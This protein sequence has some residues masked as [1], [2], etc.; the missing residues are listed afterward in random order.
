MKQ[1]IRTIKPEF[2]LHENL[3][4]AEQ[5]TGLP[6][7]MAFVGLWTCADREG[8]FEW[9]PRP[10]KACIMPYD[11]VDFSA[12]LDALSANGFIRPY[13]INGKDYGMIPSWKSH[14]VI[15]QRESESK[16]PD[17][18]GIQGV[19]LHMH[20][21]AGHS[22]AHVYRGISLAKNLRD[23][24]IARDGGIC[25]RCGDDQDL[26]VDHI[27]PRSIGGTHAES[28]LRTLCRS[29]NSGRPIGGRALEEDL[30]LDGLTM[31]DMERMCS[32]VHARVEGKGTGREGEGKGTKERAKALLSSDAD[33][34]KLAFDLYNEAAARSGLPQAQAMNDQRKSAIRRRLKDA[35]G[36]EGWKIALEKVE[37]SPHCT[38]QNDRGWKADLDFILQPKSFTRLME[39]SYDRS[40]PANH[41]QQFNLAQGRQDGIDPT[42]ANIAR[43]VGLGAASGDG[44]G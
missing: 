28:N 14:Q 35:G 10:L 22:G 29:C 24:I 8:R 11:D 41:Q 17:I 25:V 13:S 2:F 36:I 5:R 33:D 3:F 20:A 37:A 23:R 34:L 26:T 43:I 40:K 38:G 6:L 32:H 31:S 18:E 9:R 15:N 21:H 1:R 44:R 19:D 42:L 12:V 39:G 27:F 4:D 7:R 16:I 30:A